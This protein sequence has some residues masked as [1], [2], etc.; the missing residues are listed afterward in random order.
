MEGALHHSICETSL[1]FRDVPRHAPTFARMERDQVGGDERDVWQRA[2]S[3][4]Q[5]LNAHRRVYSHLRLFP[6]KG[7]NIPFESQP[8]LDMCANL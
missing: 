5:G 2:D 4:R 7:R 6:N 3:S 8:V 1:D